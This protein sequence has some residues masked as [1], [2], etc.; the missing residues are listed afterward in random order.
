MLIDAHVHIFPDAVA[1]RATER[2]SQLGSMRAY[3]D[4]TRAG[5]LAAMQRAGIDRAVNLPVATA[6]DPVTAINDWAVA[7]NVLPVYSLAAIHP[8]SPDPLAILGEAKRRGL[9][10]VKM[11]PE[12]Q[13]FDPGE[14]RL[15]SIWLACMELNLPILFHSGYDAA[16]PPPFHSSPAKFAILARRHPRLRMVLAH[17]GCLEGWRDV[18]DTLKGMPNVAVDLAYSFGIIPPD[19][20]IRLIRGLGAERVLFG[21]D[22][23][24]R[25]AAEDVKAFL[26]LSLTP[27]ERERIAWRN[28]VELLGLEV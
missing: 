7:N 8:D 18:A 10:G 21:T 24:W 9:R 14:D 27:G 1:R 19:G 13:Q 11:H 4:G 5:L 2:L 28:A 17:C 23:P 6:P 16:Y 22:S 26:A 20:L 15:E 25:D 3:A 12:Y